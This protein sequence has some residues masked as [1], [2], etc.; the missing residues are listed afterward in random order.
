MQEDEEEKD[1]KN[2]TNKEEGTCVELEIVSSRSKENKYKCEMRINILSQQ[3]ACILFSS[4]HNA[5]KEFVGRWM[6]SFVSKEIR[7]KCSSFINN[8]STK[9][10]E[11]ST[12]SQKNSFAETSRQEEGVEEEGGEEEEEGEEVEDILCTFCGLSVPLSEETIFCEACT[13]ANFL[14]ERIFAI[15]EVIAQGG[16]GRVFKALHINTGEVVAIK[17]R[18]HSEKEEYLFLWKKE[19][20]ILKRLESSNFTTPRL[21][22]VLD[23]SLKEEKQKYMI[24]EY[25]EG[26]TL[27]AAEIRHQTNFLR[28]FLILLNELNI[29]HS[30]PLAIVHRDIKPENVKNLIF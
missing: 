10:F 27:H 16:Q 30:F 11:I 2:K 18:L 14:V 12:F 23:D 5:V 21:V 17:E 20:Q 13:S 3:S 4:I 15:K 9:N 22:Y 6:S 7:V 28:M 1:E 24:L 8:E 29:L 26:E 25:V 19:I